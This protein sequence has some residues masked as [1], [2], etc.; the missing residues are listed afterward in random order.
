MSR[1]KRNYG[2]SAGPPAFKLSSIP[3]AAFV[4]MNA[5]GQVGPVTGQ[6]GGGLVFDT[7]GNVAPTT[8]ARGLSVRPVSSASASDPAQEFRT[9][10]PVTWP[11]SSTTSMSE[12]P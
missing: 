9:V 7:K 8:P 3:G 1:A 11:D 10:T 5:S 2:A 4:G 6:F 12:A